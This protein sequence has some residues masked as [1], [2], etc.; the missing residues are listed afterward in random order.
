MGH[1]NFSCEDKIF[2]N[3]YLIVGTGKACEGHVKAKFWPRL[4][5]TRKPSVLT[6]NLGPLLPMGSE[7]EKIFVS[8]QVRI[9]NKSFLHTNLK[10]GVG[11]PWA[12]HLSLIGIPFPC[13]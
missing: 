10:L 2:F 9:S 8:V 1:P 6:I 3:I 5:V 11:E 7:E 12:G 4:D 13:V